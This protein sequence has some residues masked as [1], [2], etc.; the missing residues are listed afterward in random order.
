MSKSDI[1]KTQQRVQTNKWSAIRVNKLRCGNEI[2][3]TSAILLW[4]ACCNAIQYKMKSKLEYHIFKYCLCQCCSRSK[5][6]FRNPE[7]GHIPLEH[8]GSRPHGDVVRVA[9]TPRWCYSYV[10]LRFQ[11][12][13]VQTEMPMKACDSTWK[14][15]PWTTKAGGYEI[16]NAG[17]QQTRL[18]MRQFH[19]AMKISRQ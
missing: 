16:I 13:N 10:L 9:L 1:N 8:S 4:N 3:V 7:R 2:N 11:W 15:Q 14:H 5:L 18:L 6:G 19:L 17:K 12:S